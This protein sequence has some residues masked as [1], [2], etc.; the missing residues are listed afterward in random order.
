[1]LNITFRKLWSFDRICLSS[2]YQANH[3]YEGSCRIYISSF[4]AS[5]SLIFLRRQSCKDTLRRSCCVH[6]TSDVT[7]SHMWHGYNRLRNWRWYAAIM[8]V[9]VI[10]WE[11][12]TIISSHCHCCYHW[13]PSS[14]VIESSYH[15]YQ[16]PP[17]VQTFAS[18]SSH[19]KQFTATAKLLFAC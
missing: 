18:S 2:V 19:T 1:M 14:A 17:S 12:V 9:A 3:K 5:I 10:Y 13:E 7:L 8:S 6:V 4:V 15:R 11:V 16:Q